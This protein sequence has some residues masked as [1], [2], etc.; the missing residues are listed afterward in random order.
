MTQPDNSSNGGR[1]KGLEGKM[2]R[3]SRVSADLQAPIAESLDWNNEKLI[4]DMSNWK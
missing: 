3:K 1:R 4:L 2:V